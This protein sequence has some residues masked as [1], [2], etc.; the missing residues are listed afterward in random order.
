MQFTSLDFSEVTGEAG[1]TIVKFAAFK[2]IQTTADTE[3]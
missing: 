2:Q 1:E 3:K